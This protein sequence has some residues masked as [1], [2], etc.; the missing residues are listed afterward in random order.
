MSSLTHERCSE[1]LSDYLAGELDSEERQRVEG[2]LEHCAQC[3]ERRF[4]TDWNPN[5]LPP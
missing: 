4:G 5:R 3:S 1:L 2:H